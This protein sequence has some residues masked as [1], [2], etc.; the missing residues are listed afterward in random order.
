[1]SKS[2]EGKASY[3][4]LK[5]MPTLTVVDPATWELYPAGKEQKLKLIYSFSGSVTIGRKR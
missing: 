5:G 3:L 1:M 4:G 2:V